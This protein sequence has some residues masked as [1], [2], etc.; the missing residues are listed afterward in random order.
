MI[1]YVTDESCVTIKARAAK[2]CAIYIHKL[3]KRKNWDRFLKILSRDTRKFLQDPYA[4]KLDV[5]LVIYEKIFLR[6][7]RDSW[8]HPKEDLA[9]RCAVDD[10]DRIRFLTNSRKKEFPRK[11]SKSNTLAFLYWLEIIRES[12][13]AALEPDRKS[14]W[15]DELEESC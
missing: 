14:H 10:L 5:A 7:I 2:A 3:E 12:S 11:A 4:Y 1:H 6:M 15:E 8:L 9:I 13:S